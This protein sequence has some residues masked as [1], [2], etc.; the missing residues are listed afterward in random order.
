MKNLAEFSL[1]AICVLVIG[2]AT[3]STTAQWRQKANGL[4]VGTHES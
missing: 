3:Q 4:P 1:V 2:C